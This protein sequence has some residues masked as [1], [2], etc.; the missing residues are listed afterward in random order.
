[1]DGLTPQT[2]LTLPPLVVV[3]SNRCK[4]RNVNRLQSEKLEGR[5]HLGD[6]GIYGRIILIIIIDNYTV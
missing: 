3:S 4:Q 1:L 6:L 2:L 5:S